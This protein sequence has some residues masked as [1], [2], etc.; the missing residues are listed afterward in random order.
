MIRMKKKKYFFSDDKKKK[1]LRKKE[2]SDSESDSESDFYDDEVPPTQESRAEGVLALAELL[3]A[4]EDD[5]DLKPAASGSKRGTRMI[6]LIANAEDA[7]KKAATSQTK[8]KKGARGAAA[9]GGA[10][11]GCNRRGE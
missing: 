6:D 4:T 5:G 11:G 7:I 2:G 9:R 3:A 1:H 10:P 8:I